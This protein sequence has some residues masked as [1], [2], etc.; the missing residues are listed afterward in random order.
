MLVTSLIIEFR[1]FDF[2][3]SNSHGKCNTHLR[4][5]TFKMCVCAKELHQLNASSVNYS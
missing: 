4:K 5:I 1:C 2:V 3:C